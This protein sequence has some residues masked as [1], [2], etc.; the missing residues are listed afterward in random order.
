[1]IIDQIFLFS[2]AGLGSGGGL[3]PVFNSGN[4]RLNS[5]DGDLLAA[6]DV[7]PNLEAGSFLDTVDPNLEAGSFVDTMDPS[8]AEGSFLD[9]ADPSLLLLLDSFLTLSIFLVARSLL[10]FVDEFV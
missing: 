9:T 7:D 8:L 2:C 4:S 3:D 1:M 5:G 6:E 10:E